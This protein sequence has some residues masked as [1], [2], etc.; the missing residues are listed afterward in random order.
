M[1]NSIFSVREQSRF[2]FGRVRGWLATGLLGV[3]G[4]TLVLE[5]NVALA[6]NVASSVENAAITPTIPRPQTVSPRAEQSLLVR[7]NSFGGDLRDL[8][9]TRPDQF[10]NYERPSPPVKT[11]QLPYS[12]PTPED[13]PLGPII[14]APA[15]A[16]IANFVGLDLTNFGSG[17]PPDTNGDVG[18]NYFIQSV[19]SSIGIYD[20]LTGTRVVGLSLNTFMRQG[21]FGNVCDTSNRGDPVVLYDTFEDRWIITDFA[22]TTTGNDVNNPPGMF[23]CFAASKTSD[24]VSGGWNYYSFNTTGGFGDYGKFAIW[25]DGLYATFNM[26]N[27]VASAG[28]QN[29]RVAALNKAQMYAGEPSVQIVSFDM[30]SAEFTVL[31]SNARLQSGTPPVGTPNLYSVVWQFSNAI[32]VYKFKADWN[33]IS[34]SSFTGPFTSISPTSWTNGPATVAANG[35]NAN[36]TL[37]P[38]LMAQNQYTN[39]AGVESLWNAHTVLGSAAGVAGSRYYQVNVTGGTIAANTTQAFTHS[40]DATISR[41][42]PSVAV[43]RGGNMAMV[44]SASS[45][46]LSTAI[47]YAGRL[48]ADAVNTLPQTEQSLIEGPGAQ[49]FSNRWGDYSS[50]TL[51]PDGCTFWMTT[52]YYAAVGSNWQTRIGSFKFPSCTALTTFGTLS[53]TVTLTP[54]GTPISGATVTFG[55]RTATTNVSGVYI[56]SNLPPGTYH[57][58]SAAAVGNT[59]SAAVNNLAI[60][61][62]ATTTQNFALTAAS[63]A[64]CSVDTTLTHF[65]AGVPS[66]VDLTTTPGNVTLSQLTGVLDQQ[67]TSLSGSG[68]SITTT[69]WIGQTFVPAVSG[70]L[71]QVDMNLFCAGGCSGT[72][73]IAVQIRS[74]SAG[75]PTATILA[76]ATVA[77]FTSGAGIYYSAVFGSPATLLA[78]TTYSVNARVS[79]ANSVG[80]YAAQFSSGSPY[81]SGS[82]VATTNSGTSWF[83][84]PSDLGF[85]TYM[86]SGFALSGNLIS[87]NK[88]ANP[89]ANLVPFWT[90]LSW[91]GTTPASTTLRFQ[92]AGSNEIFGPFNFV[93]PGG[94]A[95]TFFTTSGASLSQFNGFRYLKYK[96]Y[97]DTSLSTATPT[98]NDVTAC[99]SNQ[100]SGAPGSEGVQIGSVTVPAT[101]GG[102]NRITHVN[103]ARSYVNAPVVIVQPAN[104]NGDPTAL[105]ITNV[106]RSGFDVLQIEPSGSNCSG[107]TGL[108]G[109]SVVHWLAASVGSYRVQQNTR[110]PFG[111]GFSPNGVGPGPL[112]KVGTIS[113]TANQRSTAGGF[114]GWP[115]TSW[116]AVTYPAGEAFV[117]APV[118]LTTLQTWNNE[119][120]N[121]NGPVA[122]LNGTSQVWATA[123][124]NNVATGGFDVAIE[125]SEV[126][127][128][129]VAGAGLNFAEVVGYVA[130]ERPVSM[131]LT[132]FG[133]AIVV[134]IATGNSKTNDSCVITDLTFPAAAPLVDTNLRGFA[135][136]QSRLETD[137]GWLRR[138][139]MST[140]GGAIARMTVRIDEDGDIDLERLH[141]TSETIGTAIFGGD[142]ITSPITLARAAV[143]TSGD[144]LTVSFNTATEIGHLGFRI[145]GRA[146]DGSD[147]IALHDDLIFS[148][149]GDGMK[150]KSYTRSVPAAGSTEIRIED[151]DLLG[152]SRFSAAI[153][154]GADVGADAI[155]APIN[156]TAIRAANALS[157][158]RQIQTAGAK[159]LLLQVKTSG[160]QRVEFA[161]LVAA[162]WSESNVAASEIAVLDGVTPVL[163]HVQ[164]AGAIFGPGCSV[165]FL[166]VA[167]DSLYGAVNS[168]A[169]AVDAKLAKAVARGA[170]ADG[171]AVAK[172]VA[173]QLQVAPNRAYSFSAPG[174]DPWFDERVLA[175]TQ[176][177]S[178]NRNFVLPERST[179]QVSIDV[180]L[181]GGLDFAASGPDHSIA[182]SVNGVELRTLRFDGLTLQRVRLDVPE[183]L[184][185][186]SNTLTLK[187]NAD[188]GFAAD[189]VLLDGYTVNYQRLSNAVSGELKF[190]TVSNGSNGA[191]DRIFG[192]DFEVRGGFAING[193]NGLASVWTQM[194]AIVQRDEV[195]GSMVVDARVTDLILAETSQLLRPAV[196]AATPG[197]IYTT[198]TDYL[199]I[200]HPLFESELTPLIALQQSRG[201]SVRVLRTDEIYAAKSDY[202]PS[203]QAIREVISQ[204]NP[205]FVLLVGGDSYDYHDYLGVGSQSYLPTFYHAA[206]Q[207]VRFAASDALYSDANDDGAPER[208]LGRIPARTVPEL[209]LAISSIV[210]RGNTPATRYLAVAG[211]SNAAEHFDIHSRSLLSY[212]RQG[213]PKEFALVDELGITAA[214]AKAAAGLGGEADWVNYLGHSSPNRWASQNLL[215][216]SQLSGINRSGIPAVVSQWGC[217]NNYFVL[218]DQDTMAHAL[219][220][221]SNRLASSVIGSTSLA[222]DASHMALGTRFFD[223]VEDG[224]IGDRDGKV[225]NTLGEALMAAKADLIDSNPENIE[226]N[227]SITLF[228]DP[229]AVLR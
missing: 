193:M 216:T 159:K 170:L 119:G 228:G 180:D 55:S 109:T 225:I 70:Q 133:S 178:I 38:R 65:Q 69:Q 4:L 163:R 29:V 102:V 20:K 79:A 78:G 8:P 195:S 166:G 37:A 117:A 53:G 129:D 148:T 2:G 45:S 92:V 174:N 214:R 33:N 60:T 176:P 50:M 145:W 190:G 140:P 63:A 46:T 125:S 144:Q 105:R 126:D 56:F 113:T 221:R 24:P 191:S 182:L 57:G 139:A 110:A 177:V 25:P 206:D 96:A 208:A 88:F 142:F 122:S 149:G 47:R 156:W 172:T 192:G 162:D 44:Y 155:N 114:S 9:S 209:R 72:A 74:T 160:I 185:T 75:L 111:I 27:Y 223:L 222:E 73:P 97:L 34:L 77:S 189:V 58:L 28:F 213:Q 165:E 211:A 40:P 98:L 101:I 21:N 7:A 67:N 1:K 210:Q 175:T 104:D 169:I 152:R 85:K 226:S 118:V 130:I 68:N 10:E 94:T 39:I 187:V 168:Y 93:G 215:D 201:Y 220:L 200:T 71:V 157:P 49:T 198:P 188:T 89:A 136:K 146:N 81:A 100:L 108:T 18:P 15:P 181:W 91:T 5:A 61:G 158:I 14:R 227:Y 143:Q 204:I 207:I 54:G 150:A 59:T 112:L 217:W 138:C 83:T 197:N 43:D 52:E 202:A 121:L 224:R 84:Q 22:F 134:G 171:P 141:P 115:A 103:F 173:V 196:V 23:Q 120:G 199:I 31:P 3:L 116:Q 184:I 107:C 203:P 212:L 124:A 19:N 167:S 64:A 218:P 179:G 48:A 80:T 186:D 66:S 16:P 205:R 135:G 30:P 13:L 87:S 106:T 17:Y 6:Q 95:A 86:A 127:D 154:V 219:M 12:G 128:D 76:T 62:G 26:F 132:Q 90:T 32:S 42:I 36:D 123:V 229:A 51:D 131:Q 99:Y 183:N 194:G 11:V 151:V 153:A 164:C 137:G 147:W 41:Y 161:D 82:Q 35:G